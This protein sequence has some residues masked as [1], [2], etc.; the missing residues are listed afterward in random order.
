MGAT[1]G[2]V[3]V[4]DKGRGGEAEGEWAEE[5]APDRWPQGGRSSQ[6][7]SGWRRTMLPVA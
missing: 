3:E 6:A 1:V 7:D 5:E 4:A 2:M